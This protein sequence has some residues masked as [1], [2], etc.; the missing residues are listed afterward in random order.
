M[1]GF[2]HLWGSLFLFPIHPGIETLLKD[3]ILSA[4]HDP[5]ELVLL[6]QF[7]DCRPADTEHILQFFY[8]VALLHTVC[9]C[10]GI[11]ISLPVFHWSH[12]CSSLHLSLHVSDRICFH[13]S[14]R[15]HLTHCMNLLLLFRRNSG[16]MFVPGRKFLQKSCNCSQWIDLFV[17][18]KYGCRHFSCEDTYFLLFFLA[19]SRGRRPMRSVCFSS[20]RGVLLIR[21]RFSRRGRITQ[22]EFSASRILM[23]ILLPIPSDYGFPF[24][25]WEISFGSHR[26]VH[27]AAAQR[28]RQRVIAERR[29]M[30]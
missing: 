11:L 4:E 27:S 2:V 30:A 16:E 22:N 13:V 5:A 17:A 25:P 7:V 10:A 29:S 14:F 3:E 12:H 21:A 20:P 26:N 23:G 1:A 6:K 8:G 15:I 19:N 9:S 24:W 18:D 28:S